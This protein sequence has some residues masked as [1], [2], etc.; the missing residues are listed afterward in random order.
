[1]LSRILCAMTIV[2]LASTQIYASRVVNSMIVNMP[3][4][5][6]DPVVR[7]FV[8]SLV[9][10]ARSI[11]L[12]HFHYGGHPTPSE[13]ATLTHLKSE[14]SDTVCHSAYL[15]IFIYSSTCSCVPNYTYVTCIHLYVL[16]RARACSFV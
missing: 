11:L 16:C 5:L 15:H 1:M 2:C 13:L 4:N 10:L 8:P 7:L 6:I 9:S 14:N 3:K 12:F